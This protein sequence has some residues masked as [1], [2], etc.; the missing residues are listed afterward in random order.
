M[1]SLFSNNEK[2][3]ITSWLDDVHDTFVR[4]VYAFV[5]EK[6]TADVDTNYNPLYKRYKDESK[7]VTDKILTKYTIS[8]RVHYYKK[9]E[10]DVLDDTGLPSSEN[11]IRL[12]VDNAGKEKLKIASFVEVD[13]NKCSIVSD[14]E[15][16]G[17]FQNNYYKVYVKIEDA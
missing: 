8:A 2:N 1:A 11:V 3:E 6:Q 7:G 4:D 16:I 13:G 12:K 10:E 9:G 14:P 15:G 5:E 17:P